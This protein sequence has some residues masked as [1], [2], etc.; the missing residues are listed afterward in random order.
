VCEPIAFDTTPD[1]STDAE[2]TLDA[3]ASD[4]ESAVDAAAN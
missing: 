4:A 3:D 1:S 2:S